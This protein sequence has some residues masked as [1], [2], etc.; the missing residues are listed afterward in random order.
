VKVGWTE[1]ASLDL[2]RILAFRRGLEPDPASEELAIR[3]HQRLVAVAE[4]LGTFPLIGR[5][6]GDRRRAIV[7][8]H[9]IVYEILRRSGTVA[10]LRLR[11]GKELPFGYEDDSD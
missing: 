11:H 1:R 8:E 5:R 4:G 7:G 6:L 9:V 10:I 3:L 2:E